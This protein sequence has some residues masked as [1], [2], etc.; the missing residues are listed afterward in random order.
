MGPY[1]PLTRYVFDD[2]GDSFTLRVIHFVVSPK[3]KRYVIFA[4]PF[5]FL[6]GLMPPKMTCIRIR[7][8]TV[9]RLVQM[10]LMVC[11]GQ[12]QLGMPFHCVG[13]LATT[14]DMV[15][16]LH[17]LCVGFFFFFFDWTGTFT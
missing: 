5:H 4:L 9:L 6:A 7:I 2:K 11:F 13:G 14:H 3:Y 16:L 12:L 17:S 15:S 1:I 8:L 10:S